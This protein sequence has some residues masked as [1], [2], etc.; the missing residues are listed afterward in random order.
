LELDQ[1]SSSR[2]T[3]FFPAAVP[4]KLITSFFPVPVGEATVSEKNEVY[5]TVYDSANLT[6]KEKGAAL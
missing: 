1:L 6:L 4:A 5:P 2:K 3:R